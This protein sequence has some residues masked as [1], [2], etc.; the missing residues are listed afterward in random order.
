MAF[1]SEFF[2]SEF[3]IMHQ[4]KVG[5]IIERLKIGQSSPQPAGRKSNTTVF[6]FT[7]DNG[8]VLAGDRRMTDGY[9][10]IASDNTIK[11]KQLSKFSAIACA[12]SCN[13]IRYLEDNMEAVCAIFKE[14]YQRELS[15]DGQAN[16]LRNLM[17]GWWYFYVFYWY[18][19]I[20]VPVLATYDLEMGQPRIF[21]FAEDGFYFE[22]SFLAGT[23]CGFETVRGL[24]VDRWREDL[25][26]DL[27][28]TLAV[29]AMIHSGVASHG[30]S[31]AR[32]VPPKVALIDKEGFRWVPERLIIKKRDDLLK[33]IR[34]IRC[35]LC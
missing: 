20:G 21:S 32:I 14:R 4:E 12:G 23:G 8:V 18:W 15:P 29:R 26:A 11:V 28:I 9:Y 31:D 34:G 10:E 24:I 25:D 16:H 19:S 22:P 17:E 35:L 7:Y 33:E 6:A 30:V 1:A 27:A 13:I 3:P 5:A 2:A